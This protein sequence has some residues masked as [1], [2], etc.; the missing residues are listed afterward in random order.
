MSAARTKT[1]SAKQLKISDATRAAYANRDKSRDNRDP[2]NPVMP[3]EFWN[4]AS[5][6][7]YYR[8]RKTLVSL[9]LDDEILAWLKS[10]GKGHLTRINEI[11]R[12]RMTAE[13]KLS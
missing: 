11:L 10:Q 8:P 9:R 2:D 1:N 13:R 5:I 12:D 4:G 7:K 3:P 6:G